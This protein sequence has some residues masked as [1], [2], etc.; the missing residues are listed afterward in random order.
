MNSTNAKK[1]F[2]ILGI[3]VFLSGVPMTIYH[4]KYGAET[5]LI[6]IVIL[7]LRLI[8]PI[9][10]NIF[11]DLFSDTNDNQITNYPNISQSFGITGIVILGMLLL[12][13]VIELKEIIGKEASML[14]Y[15]LLAI[16]IPLLIVYSIRKNK[17]NISSFNVTLENKRI[18]PYLI[19]GSI[20]LLLGVASPIISSIPVPE[21]IKKI[22]LEFGS[23]KGILAFILMVIAAPVM[24]ELIFRGII[25][26]GLL[27]NYSPLKSILISSLLFGI[28]HL[29]PWQFVTALIIGIFSGWVYYK[30]RSLIP[31]III[32]ASVNLSGFSMRFIL[33]FD[34]S[35]DKSLLELYG[36]LTNLIL[37]ISGS[38]I[39]ASICI[40]F[41]IKEFKRVCYTVSKI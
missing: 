36:G 22:L 17:T 15:Y 3:T 23:Q 16:G 5:L 33:D 10:R 9:L 2:L 41:L 25:L 11:R 26:D 39:I 27:K 30:T 24:E 28:V 34:S 14:I 29:N 13:P 38:I 4:I 31:S 8:P 6:G 32:H 1:L 40:Y 37:I 12:G 21:S 20:V 7:G 19:I 18:I 35:M